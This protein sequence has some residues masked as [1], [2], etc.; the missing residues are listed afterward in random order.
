[1]KSIIK[2]WRAPIIKNQ[3]LGVNR[4]TTASDCMDRKIRMAE[5]QLKHSFE[6]ESFLFISEFKKPDCFCLTNCTNYICSVMKQH[7][8]ILFETCF[9]DYIHLCLL[10]YFLYFGLTEKTTTIDKSVINCQASTDVL[11]AVKNDIAEFILFFYATKENL[12]AYLNDRLIQGGAATAEIA[13]SIKNGWKQLTNHSYQLQISGKIRSIMLSG[14]SHYSYIC[15]NSSS[16]CEACTSLNGQV[17]DISE[18]EFG[19]NLPPMHPNCRCSITAYPPLT[20]LPEL[21]GVS[22]YTLLESIWE[23]I[24]RAIQQ[25][26]GKLDNL[27]D[28][29]STIWEYFFKESLNDVYGTYTT[30]NVDGIEYRINTASF[31]SVAIMP[32]G[33]YL[34]PEVVTAVDEQMLAL[35]K[36]RDSLPDGD[37]RIEEINAQLKEIYNSANEKER[38]IYWRKTYAFYCFGGDVTDQLTEYMEDAASN[39][40]EMHNRHWVENLEDFYQLVRNGGEMDLKNQPE[41]Q[42]SAYIFDGEIVAQDAL[43]NINYG[44]FGTY[45]NFPQSVLMAGAGFAQLRAGTWEMEYIATLFDDPRDTY[46]VL[47]GIEIYE[48]SVQP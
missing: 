44:F 25:A 42:H 41:W 9:K 22:Q 32:D 28:K 29:V 43:G 26:E 4:I 5:I 40:V 37:T 19:K 33:T 46:R 13:E 30:I 10:N 21:P 38:H 24:E 34:V 3:T 23:A 48:E 2:Y 16:S 6:T 12:G 11:N 1:M 27:A 20:E 7:L 17:F 47:Q 18:A 35:M 39:Y 15:E 31:E 45:C 36:E 14:R 8:D